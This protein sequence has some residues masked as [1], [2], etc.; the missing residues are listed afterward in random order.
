MSPPKQ[1]SKTPRKPINEMCLSVFPSYVCLHSA[2]TG[3]GLHMGA[4]A[5]NHTYACMHADTYTHT[6]ATMTHPSECF[7]F[8]CDNNKT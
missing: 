6:Q 7:S 4:R 5:H 1:N 8:S 3:T 2:N